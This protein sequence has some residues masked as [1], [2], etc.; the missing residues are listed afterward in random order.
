[1][2]HTL[3]SYE[4]G[5]GVLGVMKP[6][7][8]SSRPADARRGAAVASTSSSSSSALRASMHMRGGAGVRGRWCC[9]A[10][11]ACCAIRQRMPAAAGLSAKVLR[12][13]GRDSRQLP[14]VASPPAVQLHR[15]RA[16]APWCRE[17]AAAA[18]DHT[19]MC[20]TVVFRQGGLCPR[21]SCAGS[22][23][24]ARAAQQRRTCTLRPPEA[25]D[26]VVV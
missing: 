11:A 16:R 12:S 13:H 25:G 17:Q 14:R 23:H 10:A 2:L 15:A 9:A 26:T 7:L 8:V 20:V 1:L 18:A 5:P 3:A 24:V 4:G 6:V 22:G 19:D 21:S